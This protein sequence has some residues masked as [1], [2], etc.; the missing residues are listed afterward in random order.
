MQW[1]KDLSLLKMEKTLNYLPVCCH[2][3]L[4]ADK[5]NLYSDKGHSKCYFTVFSIFR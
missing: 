1:L 3:S 5:L 2:E 4:L